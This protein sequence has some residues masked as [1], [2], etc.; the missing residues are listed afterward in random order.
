MTDL[1][2]LIQ[3]TKISI[4]KTPISIG[5]NVKLLGHI[6]DSTL[7]WDWHAK[8]VI[9]KLSSSIYAMNSCKQVFK[10]QTAKTYVLWLHIPPTYN[11]GLLSG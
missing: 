11:M 8:H 2:N 5:S 4:N 3:T 10:H 7:S 1:P 6:L 9:S